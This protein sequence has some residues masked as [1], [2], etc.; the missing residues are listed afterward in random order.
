[1][2]AGAAKFAKIAA[3]A[4]NAGMAAGEGAIPEPMYVVERVNPWDDNSAV[5]KADAPIMDGVCGFAWVWI[6]GN[7]AFG[8][9][10]KAKGIAYKGYPTGLNIS[11]RAHGQSLTRKE[12]HAHAFAAVLKAAGIEAYAESRID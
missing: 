2:A 12:A 6:K 4:Y 7:T 10:A 11:V 1:M 5:K 8:R 9:W 3:A